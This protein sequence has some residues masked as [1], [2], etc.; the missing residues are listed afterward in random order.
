MEVEVG[1]EMGAKIT[2]RWGSWANIQAV[3]EEVNMGS[4]GTGGKEEEMVVTLPFL[5]ITPDPGDFLD[6]PA[7]LTPL[8]VRNSCLKSRGFGRRVPSSGLKINRGMAVLRQN[9]EVKVD[10][11]RFKPFGSKQGSVIF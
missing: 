1:V 10:V 7:S 11:E 9:E 8:L 5:R 3:V 4:T 2:A 6:P